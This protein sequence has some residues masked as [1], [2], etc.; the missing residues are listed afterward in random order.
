M[1][2][3]TNPNTPSQVALWSAANANLLQS[4]LATAAIQAAKNTDGTPA[5]PTFSNTPIPFGSTINVT[6]P[7][8]T[9]SGGKLAQ[10]ALAAVAAMGIGSAALGLLKANQPAA[11]TPAASTAAPAIPAAPPAPA[12]PT[13]P[14]VTPGPQTPAPAAPVTIQGTL[15]WELTP[16]GGLST[17]V[18]P[19]PTGSKSTGS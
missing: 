6:N 13:A 18:D 11:T 14:S 1:A 19:G 17:S 2:T 7:G 12:T 4:S 10:A 3:D 15:N 9:A 5:F 16:D 8:P